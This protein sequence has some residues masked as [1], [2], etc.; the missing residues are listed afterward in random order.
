MDF[1][2]IGDPYFELCPSELR[3]PFLVVNID[4]YLPPP[5][6]APP[7]PAPPAP[8]APPPSPPPP[9]PPRPPPRPPPPAL[10]PLLLDRTCREGGARKGRSP[11]PSI[12]PIGCTVTEPAVGVGA[13]RVIALVLPYYPSVAL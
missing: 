1:E 13:G 11:S 5:A 12:L 2:I 6:P 8:A 9:P 3:I 4:E 7:A 10:L